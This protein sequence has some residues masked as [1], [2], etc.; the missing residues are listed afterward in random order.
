MPDRRT[1]SDV[2][3]WC[4]VRM[5]DVAARERTCWEEY[6]VTIR[7]ANTAA[8]EQA[9]QLA[10]RRLRRSTAQLA[11]DRRRDAFERDRAVAEIRGLRL[12]G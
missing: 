11:H 5:A 6:L 2:D 7:G 9:E 1:I 3:E 8:Y 12:A 10:W 4:A